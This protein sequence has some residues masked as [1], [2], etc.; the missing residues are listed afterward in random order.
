MEIIITA[1]AIIGVVIA[2]VSPFVMRHA[3]NRPANG[4]LKELQKLDAKSNPTHKKVHMQ[5]CA[6][7]KTKHLHI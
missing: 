7:S 6:L 1:I 4:E 5:F 3:S 2:L